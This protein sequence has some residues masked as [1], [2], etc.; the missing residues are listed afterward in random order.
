[1][2]ASLNQRLNPLL[3]GWSHKRI[4]A[5]IP[6][7]SDFDIGR[8]TRSVDKALSI[9]NCPLVERGDSSRKRIDKLVKVSIR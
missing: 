8:Q 6:P 5:R 4:N 7:G 2:K 3:R 9:N 1:V